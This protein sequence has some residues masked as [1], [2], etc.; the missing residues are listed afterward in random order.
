MLD[1]DLAEFYQES[2]KRLNK[3]V[4]RNIKRFFYDFVFQLSVT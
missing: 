1:E 3:Q 2:S 4:K